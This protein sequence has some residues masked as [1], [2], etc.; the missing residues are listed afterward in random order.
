MCSSVV[1][2]YHDANSQEEAVECPGSGNRA[3]YV[4]A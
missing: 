4:K 2:G 1:R 3:L